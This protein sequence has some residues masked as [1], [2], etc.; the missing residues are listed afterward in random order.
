MYDES[1][2]AIIPPYLMDTDGAQVASEQHRRTYGT[3]S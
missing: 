3:L 2:Y 1:E